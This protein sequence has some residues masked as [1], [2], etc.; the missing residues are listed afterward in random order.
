MNPIISANLSA[1]LRFYPAKFFLIL[2]TL[3]AIGNMN[4]ALAV[5]W[6][7]PNQV[8]HPRSLAMGNAF[9]AIS[10]DQHALFANPA[11][12]LHNPKFNQSKDSGIF[13]LL[14]TGIKINQDLQDLSNFY[15]DNK[16]DLDD[17]AQLDSATLNQIL[18]V[19]A[20]L[21]AQGPLYL[22]YVGQGWG[23]ALVDNLNINAILGR[24]A[25][26]PLLHVQGQGHI[27]LVGGYA[28]PVSLARKDDLWL[29]VGLKV[30]YR[31]DINHEVSLFDLEELSDIQNEFVINNGIGLD[32]GLIHRV[33]ERIDLG[34]SVR[35]FPTFVTRPVFGNF[36]VG[37]EQKSLKYIKPNLVTGIAWRPDINFIHAYIPEWF[38]E[39]L[40]LS[41]DYSNY[42]DDGYTFFTRVHA[43]LEIASIF[44][45]L[46]IRAG[47]NQGYF[48]FGF[49]I[50]LV[51]FQIDY[52]RFRR[53]LGAYAGDL[54][55]EANYV[56]ISSR[57]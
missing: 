3:I 28:Y 16:D 56:T 23:V 38:M 14:E 57:F 6:L 22:G 17:P 31:G 1:K 39:S 15:S 51:I 41:F 47:I 55:E 12:L 11:G 32:L 36:G 42:F 46:F 29:G 2:L 9:Y 49:G 45:H 30:F 13:T 34:I 53:E 50:D 10:D 44:N 18:G 43:G 33:S 40:I 27:S 21:G 37:S 35:D 4:P 48:T 20:G 5:E 7:E 19:K 54:S 52:V 26:L 24:E 25:P 8:F